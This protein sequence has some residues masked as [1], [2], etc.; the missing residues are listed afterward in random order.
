MPFDGSK[1]S[2]L[3]ILPISFIYFSLFYKFYPICLCLCYVPFSYASFLPV[4]STTKQ[5]FLMATGFFYI[6]SHIPSPSTPYL[7]S[8]TFFSLLLCVFSPLPI[9]LLRAY[10]CF[11]L[12]TDL[13]NTIPLWAV[14]SNWFADSPRS[15]LLFH[16]F[17]QYCY[18]SL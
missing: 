10:L 9:P 12:C 3:F 4:A 7:I 15:S 1:C 8:F 6:L 13:S 16:I 18:I 5:S 2:P 17:I 11:S 14:G